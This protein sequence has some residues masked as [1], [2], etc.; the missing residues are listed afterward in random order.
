M[1]TAGVG[2]VNKQ[3]RRKLR[4]CLLIEAYSDISSLGWRE[5]A[6][7]NGIIRMEPAFKHGD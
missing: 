4:G 3:P 1:A 6:G 5:R 7:M 2:V